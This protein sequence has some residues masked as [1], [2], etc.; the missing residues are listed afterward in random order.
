MRVPG[1]QAYTH[2]AQ[3][4]S[5]RRCDRVKGA[6][7]VWTTRGCFYATEGHWKEG[8]DCCLCSLWETPEPDWYILH[9]GEPEG[10]GETLSISL[11]KVTEVVKKL[12]TGNAPGVDELHPKATFRLTWST[13][14][15]IW[16]E[17]IWQHSG[18][19]N[20]GHSGKKVEPQLLLQYNASSSHT[21]KRTFLVCYY[22]K[23]TSYFYFNLA[24]I[25]TK[26]QVAAMIPFSEF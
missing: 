4:G 11:A 20:A 7:R 6:G 14:L 12:C 9:R 5:A 21:W 1:G 19:A 23:W 17:P 26:V 24:I 15:F 10:S 22:V 3:L 25:A 2:G 13:L 16:M 8:P 18:D